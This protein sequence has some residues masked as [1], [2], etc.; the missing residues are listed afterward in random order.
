M[1]EFDHIPTTEIKMDI[2]ETLLKIN[3]YEK[4]ISV[5]MEN[6]VENKVQI[7][8]KEGKVSKREDFVVKLKEILE[9]RKGK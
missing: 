1:K 6:P 4:E 3:Q 7:F 8:F 5:L 2:V 9:Y